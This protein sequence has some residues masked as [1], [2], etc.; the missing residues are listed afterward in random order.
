MRA[1][2]LHEFGPA[3]NLTYETLPDPVAGPGQVRISVRAAGVHFVETVMRRGDASDMAPPLPEL[4]AVFGGEVAGVVDAVGPDVDPGW[5]GRAVVTPR[6]VPGGYA[7]LAVAETGQLHEVP[8][9][10]GHEAAVSMV[11]TGATAMGLLDVAQL[12]SDDVVL[13]TSAAGGVGRLVVQ[14]AVELGAVVIGAAGGPDKVEDVWGLGADL[15]VDYNEP[16]WT[17]LV[18][19]R[20]DGR[21]VSVVLDGVGGE[22][23]AAAF[24]LI[25]D[26]GRYVVIGWSSQEGFEPDAGVVERR[27]ISVANALLRLI[28][29]P[30]DGPEHERRALEAAAKGEL[31][32]AV[33]TFPLADAALAHAAME[34]RETTGKVVLV[35]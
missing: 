4:P 7:E 19:E 6:S 1:V 13:V 26:G 3:E 21:S 12:T 22:K 14:Y 24:G 17:D 10:L 15:A 25:G 27:R 20:L 18:R 23:S 34:R 30:E 32:P 11:M 31:V 8:D 16:G 2:V 35:P 5:L 33:Q 28:E 29:H 9:G